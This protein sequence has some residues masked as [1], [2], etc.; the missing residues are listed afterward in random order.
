M[1]PTADLAFDS[2]DHRRLYEYVERHGAVEPRE[3]WEAF[4]VDPVQFH[5]QLA[6]LQRDGYLEKRDGALRVAL[7]AG[8]AEEFSPPELTFV[9]RPGRQEDLSGIVGAIRAV[10]EEQRY[11]VAETV[12]EQLDHEDAL[13]RHNELVSRQFFVATVAGE[14]V[15]WAHVESPQLSKLG[16]TAELTLGVLEAYRRHGIGSHLL[17][18]GLEWAAANGYERVYNS[19]PATNTD[20]IAFLHRNG[21]ETEAIRSD[22]YR[23]GGGYVDEVMLARSVTDSATG[24]VF[25]GPGTA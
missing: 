12:A 21:F 5:H 11:I 18:R 6:L 3:V 15:G 19:L 4:E 8:T 22:H 7:D 25:G 10:A 20:A 14:V 1:S 9:I 24:P 23:V 2:T 17:Q 13:I 16:H